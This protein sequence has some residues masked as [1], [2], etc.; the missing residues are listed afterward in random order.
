LG[1][2]YPLAR[3]SVPSGGCAIVIDYYLLRKDIEVAVRHSQLEDAI[4]VV[5]DE[6]FFE[7]ILDNLVAI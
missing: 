7:D 6:E 1:F 5:G 2:I 3:S 4:H